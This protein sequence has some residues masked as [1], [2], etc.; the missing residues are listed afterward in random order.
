MTPERFQLVASE[1]VSNIKLEEE[2]RNEA[3]KLIQ[4]IYKQYHWKKGI[5]GNSR[6]TSKDSEAIGKNLENA[7]SPYAVQFF[8]QKNKCRRLRK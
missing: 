7:V 2:L 6:I 8:R 4:I 3:A 1:W 5:H